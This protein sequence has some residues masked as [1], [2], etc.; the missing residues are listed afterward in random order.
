VNPLAPVEHY[1]ARVARLVDAL[2]EDF[3]DDAVNLLV[4]HCMVQGSMLGG[5][6]RDA[7]TIFEYHVPATV[8]PASASY[9]ALGHLHRMQH[10][11]A[12]APVWYSGSPI[13]VDFG[14]EHDVKH[15]LLVEAKPGLPARV[16]PVPLANGWRLRTVRGT[17]DE[18]RERAATDEFGDAWLRV[19]V[20]ERARAGLADDVRAALPRALDV[21]VD[22]D[23]TP[24]YGEPTPVRTRARTPHDL[25]VEY[26][27]QS[28]HARDEPL[29]TLFDELLDTDTDA[30]SVVSGAG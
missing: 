11:P 7:Q 10:L 27:D 29:L 12:A 14:E 4:G 15:A 17:L 22:L 30:T 28:G 16:E 3:A 6:E 1:A 24:G 25:F 9:V 13:Q 23:A 19:F 5:G 20:R 8:F 26:L 2:C 21:R 18:L